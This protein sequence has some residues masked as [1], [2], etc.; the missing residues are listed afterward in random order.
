MNLFFKL[1]ATSA[2]AMIISTPVLAQSEISGVK[3]LDDRIED[4]QEQAEDNLDRSSDDERYSPLGV[5]QGWSGSVA[6]TAAATSGNTDTKDVS[7]AGRLTFGVGEWSHSFGFASEFAQA[8]DVKNKDTVYGTYEGSRYFTPKTYAFG[9]ARAE[10]DNFATT[11]KD[12]FVGAGI[13]YRILN[14]D[15]ATW[16]V[17]AGPGIRYTSDQAGVSTTEEGFLGAS[18]YYYALTDTV[19]L[20]NDTDVLGSS[21]NTKVSNDFGVNF[22]VTEAVTTRVSYRTDYNTDPAAG[23]KSSDNTLGLAVIV[24]F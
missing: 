19:S 1:A 3:D 17:Q 2:L 9:I 12:V 20:T 6:L 7:L 13:G 14:S 16:R 4:I 5:A 8:N 11:R 15:N 18:R 24:G 21:T 23:K 10:S 22:K